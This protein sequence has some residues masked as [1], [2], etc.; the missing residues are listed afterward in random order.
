M[1]YDAD[2]DDDDG[3]WKEHGM[4]VGRLSHAAKG[5]TCTMWF[6]LS[7]TTISPSACPSAS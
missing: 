1:R 2:D 3:M 4:A 5:R 7:F 6:S